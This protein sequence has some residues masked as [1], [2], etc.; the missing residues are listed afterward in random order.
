MKIY[1]IKMNNALD[2]NNYNYITIYI[3]DNQFSDANEMCILI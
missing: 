3:L 1:C 2:S